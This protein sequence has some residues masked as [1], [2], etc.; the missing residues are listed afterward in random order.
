M[1][2]AESAKI[3]FIAIIAIVVLTVVLVV[4]VALQA[5]TP[6]ANVSTCDVI[7]GSGVVGKGICYP[8][9]AATWVYSKTIGVIK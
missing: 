3:M 8:L 5:A 1:I 7:E 2:T 4:A 6:S 9:K